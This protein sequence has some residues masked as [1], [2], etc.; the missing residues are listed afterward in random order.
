ML[1][2]RAAEHDGRL[3]KYYRITENGL[4]RLRE[5]KEEWQ[6]VFAIYEYITKRE[7]EDA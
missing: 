7:R 5:F 2:V 1:T 4:S 3:R 6:E